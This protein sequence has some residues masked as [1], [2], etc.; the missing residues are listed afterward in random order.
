MSSMTIE[1]QR[2]LHSDDRPA[3]R[4]RNMSL[5]AGKTC[6]TCYAYLFCSGIGCTKAKA[7]QCDYYPV[8]YRQGGSES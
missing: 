8:R 4:E 3:W 1:L 7:T 6:D 5:P 2:L